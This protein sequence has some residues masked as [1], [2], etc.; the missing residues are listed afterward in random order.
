MVSRLINRLLLCALLASVAGCSVVPR[1]GP[2]ESAI[3]P[4]AADIAGFTLI[5]MTA[6]KVVDYRL[7][8]NN[9]QAGTAGI[10]SA[11][12]IRLA[13]GDMLKIKISESKE[14]G[15][16]APLATGGTPF[17][18]I[19]IDDSGTI[20]LP[21]AGRVK[22][23]GLDPQQVE[24][25]VRARLAGVTFEPQVF[26]E[27]MAGRATS[28]LVSGEVRNP[29]RFS[30]LDGPLTLIDAINKAG[31]ADKAP[32]QVDVV[33]RRGSKVVRLPLEFVQDG[34]NQEL[35]PGDEVILESDIKYFNALGA[36]TKQG[37]IDFP[38]ANPSLLD[39]LSQA[40]GLNTNT[41][42]NTGVF[43]FRLLE[44]KAYR[45]QNGKWQPGAAIFKF[46][47]SKPETMF[48]AQAFALKPQDTIYVTNAPSVEW[49]RAL[50]PIA[51]TLSIVRSGVALDLAVTNL[52]NP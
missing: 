40:G 27:L 20:S 39:G 16:F 19:R 17:D 52:G 32:H 22:V 37:Q 14:G 21:Y 12:R 9:D 33:I 4:A 45:D 50:L 11:P 25:R 47:M 28:V 15:L 44:P 2:G 42:S 1:A 18:N 30:M 38:I 13:P 31:G 26:V 51:T 6:D 43:V 46:D 10:P 5:D 49:T 7:V 29:G 8:K 23:A 48:I 36:T 41:A 34:N 3:S 35:R 24:D